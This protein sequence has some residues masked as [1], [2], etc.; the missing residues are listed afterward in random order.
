MNAITRPYYCAHC[1]EW[2]T[3]P[4]HEHFTVSRARA[5]DNCGNPITDPDEILCPNCKPRNIYKS[6]GYKDRADYLESLAANFGIQSNEVQVLADVL[7]ESEDFDGL[8]SS[9][10]DYADFTY[11]QEFDEFSDADPGL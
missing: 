9:L 3:H 10:E 11:T 8:I 1:D 4:T 7:G 2:T 5:C 6:K